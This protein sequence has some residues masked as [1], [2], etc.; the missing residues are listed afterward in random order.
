MKPDGT[1]TVDEILQICNDQL[2]SWERQELAEKI[3]GDGFVGQA[4]K[5]MNADTLADISGY[6][7]YKDEP[8]FDIDE[9]ST[10]D[11]IDELEDR[12]S[13]VSIT[14][15]QK[16]LLKTMAETAGTWD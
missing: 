12:L 11:L 5:E 3:I 7:V 14:R 8:E 1:Y 4:I 16:K 6:Y 9:L 13:Y 15:K 2:Q 10:S